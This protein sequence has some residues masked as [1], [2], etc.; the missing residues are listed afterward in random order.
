MKCM[1]S[2][3][4][5]Q[6]TGTSAFSLV[7]LLVAAVVASLLLVVLLAIT[8]H[9]MDN[10]RHSVE[11]AT[12]ERDANLVLDYLSTDLQA[13]A[14]PRIAQAE[15]LRCSVERVA[16]GN[17]CRLSFLAFV[18][19]SDPA[20]LRGRP[21]AVSYR[22]AF[23]DP[24]DAA[25][26]NRMYA[27]YRTVA[28]ATETFETAHGATNLETNFWHAQ[29][30]TALGNFLVG[31]VADFKARVLEKPD[32]VWRSLE[33][34]GDLLR[35]ATD[36]NKAQVIEV[37]LTLLPPRVSKLVENG[38]VSRQEAVKRFGRSFTHQIPVRSP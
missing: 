10:Y 34:P 23:Q 14:T 1:L 17:F 35:I 2:S 18:L 21:R 28:P 25:G 15:A 38:T 22:V 32:G 5:R 6:A 24:V 16:D 13:L 30:T 9:S 29:S 3:R 26:E 20:G 36:E 33:K 7:E 12:M 31:N 19:D 37:A 11:G 4:L 27:L 8:Q